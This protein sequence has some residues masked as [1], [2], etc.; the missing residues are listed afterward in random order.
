MDDTGETFTSNIGHQNTLDYCPENKCLIAGRST[1]EKC[2][3]IFQNVDSSIRSFDVA[4]AIK[5]DLANDTDIGSG[6]VNIIWAY[7]NRKAYDMAFLMS[8]DS[9]KTTRYVSL[10]QLGKGSNDLGKGTI[11][12]GVGANAFNGTYQIVRTVSNALQT[13]GGIIDRC[14]DACYYDGK[15]YEIPA[16]SRAS[17]LALLVHTIED[18]GT[19]L[20]TEKL[21][22]DER[23]GTGQMIGYQ[24]DGVEHEGIAI[25]RGKLY[26]ARHTGGLEIYDY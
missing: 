25:Y 4:N 21:F 22:F 10:M 9:N 12:S 14:N 8:F 1:T 13:I 7:N 18:F 11:I 26:T 16:P 15:I 19:T 3:F 17:G 24:N 6:N 23:S 20:K 2:V 5:I